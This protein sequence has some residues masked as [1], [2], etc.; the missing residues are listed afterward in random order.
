MQKSDL[1]ASVRLFDRF[2]VRARKALGPDVTVLRLH[3]LLNVYL[4]E[5][6]NQRNLLKLLDVTS[7][8]ALSRNLADMSAL[9]SSKKPG[10]GLIELR[11]DLMNLRQKSIHLTPR[12]RDIVN[13]IL[14]HTPDLD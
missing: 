1:Q 14:E 5:G 10:P 13:T 2:I 8:T 12:G 7:V 6:T 4:N 3:I 11:F 9:T